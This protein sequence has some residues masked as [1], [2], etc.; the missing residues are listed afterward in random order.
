MKVQVLRYTKKFFY[1]FQ[2]QNDVVAAL[3]KQSFFPLPY[4]SQFCT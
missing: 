1:I 3:T 4:R 2:K